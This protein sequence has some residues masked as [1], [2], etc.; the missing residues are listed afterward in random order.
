[1]G[2]LRNRNSPQS[3]IFL[4]IQPMT[5]S[6]QRISLLRHI[7]KHKRRMRTTWNTDCGINDRCT[8]TSHIAQRPSTVIPSFPPDGKPS[9]ITNY[10]KILTLRGIQFPHIHNLDFI[11]KPQ[12]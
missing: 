11:I 5:H 3:T 4:V 7:A 6:V 1:M 2:L 10:G 12:Y 8:I 9:S